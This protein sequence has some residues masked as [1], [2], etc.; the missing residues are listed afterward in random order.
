MGLGTGLV[1]SNGSEYRHVVGRQGVAQFP[2]TLSGRPFAHHL[3]AAM[4]LVSGVIGPT[5]HH[6]DSSVHSPLFHLLL[7]QARSFR[8]PDGQGLAVMERRPFGPLGTG[9]FSLLDRL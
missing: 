2:A 3:L 7:L 9:L 8:H 1:D 6:Q 5:I 4:S